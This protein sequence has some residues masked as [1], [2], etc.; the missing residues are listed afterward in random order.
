M[1][2]KLGHMSLAMIMRI[3]GHLGQIRHRSKYVEY[4]TEQHKQAIRALLKAK[5]VTARRMLRVVAYVY[6]TRRGSRSAPPLF[7][8][9]H[10]VLTSIRRTES[11]GDE[12]KYPALRIVLIIWKVLV[13]VQGLV[14]FSI[15]AWA[16]FKGPRN[17]A[18]IGVLLMLGSCLAALV[19]WALVELVQ[20]VMDIEENTRRTAEKAAS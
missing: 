3:Y 18:G 11:A 4:R 20:V 8:S 17:E 10:M 6:G 2:A 19:Q 1:T 9:K 12:E 5:K 7:R 13:V 16:T 15:G 14:V